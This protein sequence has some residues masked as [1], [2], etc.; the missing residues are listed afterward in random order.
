MVGQ[1]Y[2]YSTQLQLHSY[3]HKVALLDSY[4]TLV[5]FFLIGKNHLYVVLG[6]QNCFMFMEIKCPF[7]T[8]RAGNETVGP[9]FTWTHNLLIMWA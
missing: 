6:S 8:V 7:V 3:F 4:E 9:D 5:F 2:V 1:V